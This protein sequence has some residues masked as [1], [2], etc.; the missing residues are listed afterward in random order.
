M[1]VVSSTVLHA[2]QITKAFSNLL[3]DKS[4]L[5]SVRFTSWQFQQDVTASIP[6]SFFFFFFFHK[7]KGGTAW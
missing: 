2:L 1:P 6:N 3:M 7:Y 5:S 4:H